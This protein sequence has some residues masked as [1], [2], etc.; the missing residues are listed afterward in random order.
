MM[1]R[2]GRGRDSLTRRAFRA[3]VRRKI[4]VLGMAV[5]V[6]VILMAD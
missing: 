5:F 2:S 3:F 1:D 6:M 4:A